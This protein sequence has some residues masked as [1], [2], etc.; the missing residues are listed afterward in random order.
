MVLPP[1]SRLSFPMLIIF[2][3][4]RYASFKKPHH[5]H[6][7]SKTYQPWWI[8]SFDHCWLDDFVPYAPAWCLGNSCCRSWHASSCRGEATQSRWQQL[9]S[10]S[11]SGRQSP[12]KIAS[13]FHVFLWELALKRPVLVKPAATWHTPISRHPHPLKSLS[14]GRQSATWE[15]L[16]GRNA[17]LRC[18]LSRWTMMDLAITVKHIVCSPG[19][20]TLSSTCPETT[21]R[22]I[23]NCCQPLL[24][25]VSLY[26]PFLIISEQY[27]PLFAIGIPLITSINSYSLTI[28]H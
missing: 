20:S 28:N 14:C 4:V 1:N 9:V 8:T 22:G 10:F 6:L 21:Q 26:Q 18:K 24:A 15:A 23:M 11:L 13:F 17:P 16:I 19:W 7:S 25:V 2:G 5:P 3:P 12:T 27:Q